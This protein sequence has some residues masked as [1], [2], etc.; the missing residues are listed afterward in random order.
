MVLKES[1]EY[2]PCG[3]YRKLNN[4]TIQDRYPVPHIQDSYLLSI[5]FSKM[6]LAKRYHQVPINPSD[7]PKTAVITPFGLFEYIKMPFGLRS[8]A[9]T[10]QLMM[11]NITRDLDFVFVYLDDILITSTSEKEH[12]RHIRIVCT[13]LKENGL[14]LNK[15]KCIFATNEINFLGHYIDKHGIRPAE[16]KISSINNYPKPSTI[17]EL[18]KCIGMMNFYHRFIPKMV[19]IIKPLYDLIKGPTLLE[20]TTETSEA[21]IKSKLALTNS[22]ML[23][24][25]STTS[26]LQITVDASDITIGAALEQEIE[27]ITTNCLLLQEIKPSPNTLQYI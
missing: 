19:K 11:D 6:D 5:I 20:W 8:S 27:G 18:Q 22:T 13:I 16:N 1:G 7:I 12:R 23:V 17:K 9:Q 21:F 10:F 14:T 24:H 25:P 2:R 4:Q 26:P 15:S 3:D